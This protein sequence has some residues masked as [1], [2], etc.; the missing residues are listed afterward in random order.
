MERTGTPC[1]KFVH[2]SVSRNYR[3]GID[4]HWTRSC[5]TKRH[6]AFWESN[7][8]WKTMMTQ[9]WTKPNIGPLSW[10]SHLCFLMSRVALVVGSCAS[11]YLGSRCS[12]E[13]KYLFSLVNEERIEI[14]A[15]FGEFFQTIPH[16]FLQSDAHKAPLGIYYCSRQSVI[17]NVSNP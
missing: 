5:I 10:E 14:N 1:H 15:F 4:T 11:S 2:V 6:L 12:E 13:P 9:G 17:S 16:P 8:A 7:E 3:Q